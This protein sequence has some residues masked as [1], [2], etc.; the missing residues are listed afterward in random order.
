M[1]IRADPDPQHWLPVNS[2]NL[3]ATPRMIKCHTILVTSVVDPNTLK[4]D[5]D[6]EFWPNLDPGRGSCY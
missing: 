5:P 1:R 3:Q 4:L 6:P 2:L